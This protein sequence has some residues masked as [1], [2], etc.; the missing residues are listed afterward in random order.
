MT[1]TL[2]AVTP[3]YIP[4]T[5]L[6]AGPLSLLF[7]N[8]DLRQ[9][10]VG[11]VEIVQRIYVAVRDQD[12]GTVPV[13]L[14]DLVIDDHGDHFHITFTAIHR[15]NDIG[16]T[17]QGTIRGN[18]DGSLHF[19]MDGRADTTFR[20]NRIGFCI[21][22]PASAAGAPVTLTHSDGTR[23]ESEFPT[24]ISPHQPFM[25]LRAITHEVSPGL[26]AEVSFEGDIFET[27]DQ[28]NWTDASY[29]TYSTPLSIPYPVTAEAGTAIRQAIGVRL[30]GQLPAGAENAVTSQPLSVI[31][32]DDP[33]AKL[34]AIGL[35]TA[36]HGEPLSPSEAETLRALRLSHLR[37]DLDLNAQGVAE[38]VARATQDAAA[39]EAALEIALFIGDDV[40]AEI[41]VLKQAIEASKPPVARW[42]VFARE[43][44]VTPPGLVNAIR[45]T[46]QE[47]APDAPIGGGT[48]IYFV[49]L[50]RNHPPADE[51]D[52]VTY[53]I[54]PQVHAF[55][56]LSLVENMTAQP[57]SVESARV[58]SNNRPV[59]ISP[60]TLRARFNP[61]A[62]GPEEPTP[63]GELPAA[64]DVRQ[65]SAFA[66]GW[67][68][69]SLSHLAQAGVSALTYYETTGWRGVMEREAG[70]VLPDKFPSQPG[71]RFP[72]YHLFAALAPY[73]GGDVLPVKVN[74]P[75][76]IAALCVTRGDQRCTIIGNLRDSEARVAV[77][78]MHGKITLQTL[79]DTSG[80]IEFE[81]EQ[82]PLWVDLAPFTLVTLQQSYP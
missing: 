11:G 40:Q 80:S 49:H 23:S 58:I 44:V 78:G 27:E 46:L 29:K 52:F 47:L 12:W 61:D 72:I 39:L 14:H 4:V 82:S 68:L 54:N 37:V 16:F 62:L 51:L 17:W 50:N 15:Q 30:I 10:R 19:T 79:G 18:T 8:G 31:I 67:T 34:P 24:L 56:L 71:M 9:L 41:A 45:P 2:E 20:R 57:Y 13:T 81:Q 22:H 5:P 77:Y 28:R 26:Q 32:D 75:L 73:A 74:E 69:G 48:N 25:D 33:V 64:V 1:S 35:G 59:V 63:P 3:A 36:S 21:L 65:L 66:A 7:S 53:S 38:T 60:I 76:H 55:D 43:A 6:R 42:L 70:P